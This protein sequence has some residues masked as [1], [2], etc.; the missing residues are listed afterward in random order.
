M[1]FS[2]SF[3]GSGNLA[4]HL[5]P[6]LD[7]AGYPVHEVYSP[8]RQHARK[9]VERLYDGEVKENLDFSTSSSRLVIIAV[10]DDA[11]EQVA[12]EI[13]LP[14]ETMLVH[15]S[16]SRPLDKLAYAAASATGVFYPLQMFMK[17]A[18]TDFSQVPIFIESESEAVV[19]N[20]TNMA[21]AISQQVYQLSSQKRLTLHLAAVIA[22]DFT[23]HMLTLAQ[24]IARKN[25]L[26][27]GW[28]KP[29][30]AETI[31]KA[32]QGDPGELQTGVARR[33][34]FETLDRHMQV[35]ENDPELADIYRL[36]SQ[37]IVD[38]YNGALDE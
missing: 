2:V 15:T 17:G 5:A 6:A 13:I 16:G 35:L 19:H 20:L 12:R 37:H 36:I 18:K 26:K 21:R 11:I 38:R 33:S 32:L 28:L 30:I 27:F 9:L 29:L 8:T 25:E 10:P 31:N 23:N 7:N 14:D 4:W 3:V 1:S 34:D 24:E 22:S